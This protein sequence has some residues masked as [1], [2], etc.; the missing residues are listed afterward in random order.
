MASASA[1][2]ISS[3]STQAIIALVFG[4]I[5]SALGLIT[6]W[7]GYQFWRIWN[8]RSSQHDLEAIHVTRMHHHIIEGVAPIFAQR[9][10]YRRV[11]TMS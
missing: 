7:Q 1:S 8:G 5:A 4:L 2:S 3:G 9:L 10:T 11:Q 6:V